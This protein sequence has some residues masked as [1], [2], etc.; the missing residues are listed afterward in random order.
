HDEHD[1]HHHEDEECCCGHHHDEHDHHHHEDEECCCGHHH[2]E[3]EHH[4]HE[5][6]ECC[7]GHHHHAD[8]I[9]SSVGIET[10]KKFDIENLKALLDKIA[11]G[12]YGQIVR[13]KGIVCGLD[14]K[15]YVFNL[16]PDEVKLEETKAI[17]MGKIVVIGAHIDVEEIKKLF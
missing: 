6:E 8:E 13:S 10:I 15:W 14:N 7:C 11:K 1:H 3:H 2:D 12:K 9:F 4:H 16:T 17:P 5:D